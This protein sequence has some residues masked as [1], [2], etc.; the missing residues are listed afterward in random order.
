MEKTIITRE[1]LYELVW[2]MPMT[3]LAKKYSISDVGLRKKCVKLY[4]P[5]PDSGYWVKL[6]YNKPV[7]KVALPSNYSGKKDIDLAIRDE[8]ESEIDEKILQ[9]RKIELHV[10][11]SLGDK[12]VVPERLTR[13]NPL[14]L[15]TKEYLKKINR[16]KKSDWLS[17]SDGSLSID[18]STAQTYRALIFM[19][20]LI[21]ALE[22]RGHKVYLN[23]SSTIVKVNDIEINITL[24]EKTKRE[25]VVHPIYKWTQSEYIFSGVLIF[26]AN[27]SYNGMTWTDGKE[28]IEKKLAKIVARIETLAEERR[29]E[30]I[31]SEKRHLLY[32]EEQRRREELRRRKQKDLLDLEKLMLNAKR[33]HDAECMRKFIN[34]LEVKA[35]KSKNIELFDWII[36]ARKKADWVDPLVDAEDEL[37]NDEDLFKLYKPI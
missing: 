2:S 29:I 12:L 34:E 37:L 28:L 10:N 11:T 32:L 5:L 6:K 3:Q 20:T 1:E 19:D 14:I 18:V 30:I 35:N 31:E 9:Q 13:P 36:W 25:E 27:V 7:Q 8:S 26:N 22:H 15:K 17:N 23:N 16:H 33:L 4:I 21:K 24:R